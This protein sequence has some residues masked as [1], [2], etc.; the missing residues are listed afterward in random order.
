MAHS[1]TE[2]F[3]VSLASILYEIL[4]LCI[5]QGMVYL[6]GIFIVLRRRRQHPRVSRL[7]FLGLAGLF[8]TQVMTFFIGV[9][10]A[11]YLRLV[12]MTEVDLG[13]AGL[14]AL[15]FLEQVVKAV[16]LAFLIMAVLIDRSPAHQAP[17]R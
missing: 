9:F 8:L 3:I 10:Y 12:R 14:Q 11:H 5:P 17:S 1:N 4:P 13:S 7:A 16:A 15:A 2:T 6:G